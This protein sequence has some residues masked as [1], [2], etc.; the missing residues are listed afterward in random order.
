MHTERFRRGGREGLCFRASGR[1][2]SGIEASYSGCPTLDSKC[3]PSLFCLLFY[4]SWPASIAECAWLFGNYARVVEG[5][6]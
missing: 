3:R 1:Y 4:L 6:A 2:L 5:S